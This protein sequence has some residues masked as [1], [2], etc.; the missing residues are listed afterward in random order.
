M[1]L[2]YSGRGSPMV[3]SCDVKGDKRTTRPSG[4]LRGA[5]SCWGQ[6]AGFLPSRH[7]AF[8]NEEVKKIIMEINFQ[9]AVA[10]EPYQAELWLWRAVLQCRAEAGNFTV[11]VSWGVSWT[12][13]TQPHTVL[14]NK[15]VWARVVVW[16]QVYGHSCHL[17]HTDVLLA[18]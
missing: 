13:F 17:M 9:T 4:C 6:Q 16:L 14:L 1:I 8:Y 18:N 15:C 2:F 5:L 11:A 7:D 3:G 10:C 12:G